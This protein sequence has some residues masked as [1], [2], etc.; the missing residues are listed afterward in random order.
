[1]KPALFVYAHVIGLTREETKCGVGSMQ[2]RQI[3]ILKE[4]SSIFEP[5]LH[6]L[7]DRRQLTRCQQT[8]D[9]VLIR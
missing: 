2:Q 6:V 7:T 3:A 4:S 8:L 1:M 9:T 5:F